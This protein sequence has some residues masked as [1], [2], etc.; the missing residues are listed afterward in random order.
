M[1]NDLLV[2]QHSKEAGV[3]VQRNKNVLDQLCKSPECLLLIHTLQEPCCN[4]VHSLAVDP[5]W[6]AQYIGA[7][8]VPQWHYQLVRSFFCLLGVGSPQVQLYLEGR[9]IGVVHVT[10]FKFVIVA[11]IIQ[12]LHVCA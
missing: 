7:E 5:A 12:H 8:N 10:V 1:V 4:A 2:E 11:R 9:R 6:V 3:V